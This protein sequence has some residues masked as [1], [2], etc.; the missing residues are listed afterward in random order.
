MSDLKMIIMFRPLNVR[1]IKE[2]AKDILYMDEI[3]NECTLLCPP[4]KHQVCQ[5]F[6]VKYVCLTPLP[7]SICW[8]V[9]SQ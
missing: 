4:P 3:N 5:L 7:L 6:S 9:C 1:E 2:E 8:L